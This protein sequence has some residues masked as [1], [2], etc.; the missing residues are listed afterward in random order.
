MEKNAIL[1]VSIKELLHEIPAVCCRMQ[2]LAHENEI[3]RTVASIAE[4]HVK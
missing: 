2:E 3:R 4:K 1:S